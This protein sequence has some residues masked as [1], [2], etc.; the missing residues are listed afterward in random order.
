MNRG[1]SV[2]AGGPK[3]DWK[4]CRAKLGAPE[5]DDDEDKAEAAPEPCRM[6]DNG[7]DGPVKT[8]SGLGLGVLALASSSSPKKLLMADMAGLRPAR[9]SGVS[10]SE[11][12]NGA[13]KSRP[14]LSGLERRLG[15]PKPPICL[16]MLGFLVKN[17]A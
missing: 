13:E 5:E 2:V 17:G 1:F 14:S 7:D 11:G 8:E 4:A 9:A 16:S 3:N 15:A 10:R 6:L 12:M